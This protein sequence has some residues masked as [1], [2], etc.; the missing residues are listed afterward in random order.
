MSS[1]QII[2]KANLVAAKLDEALEDFDDIDIFGLAKYRL[3][4]IDS[5]TTTLDMT[6]EERLVEIARMTERLGDIIE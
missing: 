3:G 5:L 2:A 1:K 6:R 4:F